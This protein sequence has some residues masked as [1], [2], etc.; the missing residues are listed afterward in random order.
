MA[1]GFL[2]HSLKR[3]PRPA[4]DSDTTENRGHSLAC[5]LA[6]PRLQ[7]ADE[8]RR[9]GTTLMLLAVQ[10]RHDLRGGVRQHTTTIGSGGSAVKPSPSTA[11]RSI[12]AR[13]AARSGPAVA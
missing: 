2:F 7:R 1:R 13:R 6:Q 5:F 8:Q 3:S 10:S 12:S 9:S 11:R 4:L